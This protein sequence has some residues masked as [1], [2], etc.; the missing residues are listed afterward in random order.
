MEVVLSL[1]YML[2]LNIL[3]NV[4]ISRV[5]HTY[6]SAQPLL[7]PK[8]SF[9]HCPDSSPD[10]WPQGSAT[11]R[12]T[13]YVIRSMLCLHYNVHVTFWRTYNCSMCKV[14]Q[15]VLKKL[16]DEI[17]FRGRYRLWD[18]QCNWIFCGAAPPLVQCTVLWAKMSSHSKA[19]QMIH[20]WEGGA[21]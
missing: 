6:Q 17:Q 20:D 16:S 3:L 12:Y 8:F 10:I 9:I 5:S 1:V 15:S 7:Q 2:L 4:H 21:K 19:G 18:I 13:L 11:L 14:T